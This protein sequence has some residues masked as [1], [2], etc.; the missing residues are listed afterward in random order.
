MDVKAFF[1]SATFTVTY[2]VA[3]AATKICAI[4]D[5]VLDFDAT[6]GRASHTAADAVIGYIRAAGLRLEWIL[7]TH[8]HA[9][10]LS[11]GSYIKSVLGGKIAIGEHI[12]DV[13]KI[14]AGIFNLADDFVADG[15]QFDVLFKHGET[16]PIGNLKATVLHTPG[17]T[18]AC[19]TYVIEDAAFIGDTMFMPDYG[20]S[21][22]DFPGGDARSLYRSIR[23]ILSLP[24]DTRLF[25]CHDYKAPG[26]DT[27][28]W[29]STVREQRQRNVHVH[30]G[31]GED[32]FTAMRTARDKT[33]GMPHLILPSIQVNIRA[34]ALP[35][36]EDNG[37]SYLKLPINSL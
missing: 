37:V 16:F 23:Q 4:I 36:P 25:T 22:A 10:H 29:E 27:F 15:R 14:F 33:L 12:V 13:Q 18:P 20:T 35:P 1:D 17:H 26:R 34:G 19:L 8:A 30:D 24:A 28:A 31:I 11:A 5:P 2:L 7:E 9:D 32:E 3:D 6:S 21:R